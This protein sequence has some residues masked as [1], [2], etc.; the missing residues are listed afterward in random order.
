MAAPRRRLTFE[1]GRLVP[2]STAIG[3]STASA[4]RP[5]P[6]WVQRIQDHYQQSKKQYH[7]IPDQGDMEMIDSMQARVT[8][9]DQEVQNLINC[10]NSEKAVI[11]VE[12]DDVRRD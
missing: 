5:L 6:D 11:E 1:V 12:F 8:H 10:C 4:S 2:Y 3:K 7:R 9:L